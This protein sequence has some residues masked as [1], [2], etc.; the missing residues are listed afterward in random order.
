MEGLDL[1]DEQQR[2]I[3]TALRA[4]EDRGRREANIEEEELEQEAKY[5]QEYLDQAIED[6]KAKLKT[7]IVGCKKPA[8]FDPEVMSITQYFTRMGRH[9]DEAN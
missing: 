7:S 5:T 9:Q 1:T 8:S 4:A 2:I 6:A 3:D